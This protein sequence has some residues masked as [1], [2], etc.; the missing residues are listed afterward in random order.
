MAIRMQTDPVLTDPKLTDPSVAAET[1]VRA[2]ALRPHP[3]G[4]YY[5]ETWR[6]APAGGGRGAATAILFLLPSGE[7]SHW[8]R[9]DATELWLW[10]AGAALRLAQSADGVGETAQVLGPDLASGAQL[11]AVVPPGCWQAA[12]SL[13]P[14][15]LVS[16]VV[17]PAFQFSGFELAPP[18]WR[19]RTQG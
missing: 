12:E 1:V 7:C 17:A 14:W 19:P 6:D 5:R 2:L 4:G 18:G 3:E 13:G 11:Q 8:H 10:H 15:V 9:V 16:C